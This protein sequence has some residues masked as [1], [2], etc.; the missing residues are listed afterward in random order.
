MCVSFVVHLDSIILFG[1]TLQP[2]EPLLY[3][4]KCEILLKPG[5]QGMYVML[6]LYFSRDPHFLRVTIGAVYLML[7]E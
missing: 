6:S 1:F 2:S 3:D 7:A 4:T 5:K